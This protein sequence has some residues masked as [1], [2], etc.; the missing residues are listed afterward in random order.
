MTELDWKRM[1]EQLKSDPYPST[2]DRT[3]NL[4][5]GEATGRT[6]F[7]EQTEHRRGIVRTP[8][9]ERDV[10]ISVP[11][12][13]D[14]FELAAAAGALSPTMEYKHSIKRPALG[15]P[16]QIAPCVPE[17][18]KE[19]PGYYCGQCNTTQRVE[20]GEESVLARKCK[21]IPEV[22]RCVVEKVDLNA[23]IQEKT[24]GALECARGAG[25]PP[26]VAAALIG[27]QHDQTWN[28]LDDLLDAGK[29]SKTS[30]TPDEMS[31]TNHPRYWFGEPVYYKR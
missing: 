30:P 29:A 1:G 23:S 25:L 27:E 22:E 6:H 16:D 18:I 31:S 15:R 26:S 20:G 8:Q 11:S 10:V 17:V 7:L 2:V 14:E 12:S 21:N 28:A 24:Q 4:R 3:A 19:A 13:R 5:P 9:G